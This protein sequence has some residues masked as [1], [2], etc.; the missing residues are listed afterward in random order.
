VGPDSGTLLCHEATERRYSHLPLGQS[1]ATSLWVNQ[2]PLGPFPSWS[3]G[4]RFLIPRL[5]R[6]PGI[7]DNGTL[8]PS[9]ELQLWKTV[10]YSPAY[11]FSMAG[12]HVVPA[13]RQPPSRVP[14]CLS[15]CL[16]V[17]LLGPPTPSR[18]HGWAGGSEHVPTAGGHGERP[19]G[20]GKGPARGVSQGH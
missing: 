1:V 15:V 3:I 7:I 13:P 12:S 4:S 5:D 19:G 17:W 9:R 8:T 20:H 6:S 14:V 10:G 16:S 18:E 2:W 11:R